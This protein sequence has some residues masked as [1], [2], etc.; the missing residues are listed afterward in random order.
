MVSH[1]ASTLVKSALKNKSILADRSNDFLDLE[2]Y[3]L[4]AKLEEDH[5]LARRA[6]KIY[7]RA[8][9]AVEPEERFTVSFHFVFLPRDSFG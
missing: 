3:L 8:T 9:E 2:L 7:E 5:G 6:I 4:Y 1:F